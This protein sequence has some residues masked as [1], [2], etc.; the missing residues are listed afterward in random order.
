MENLL[1][2]IGLEIGLEKN[3]DRNLFFYTDVA[4]ESIGKLTES[5]VAINEEDEYLTKVYAI[6]DLE[7]KRPPIKIYI[8]SYGGDV[9]SCFGLLS[10]IMGSKTPVHTIV[11]GTAQ[12][13]GSLILICG[14]RRFAYPLSTVMFHQVIDDHLVEKTRD[15]EENL[16]ELKRIQAKLEEIVLE[17][18]KISR[19]RL[20]DVYNKKI[21]WY[22]SANEAI[23]FG[24]VDEIID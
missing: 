20:D 2:K 1:S 10:I 3:L 22:L 21:D 18:T 19:K 23:K 14:H 12:S 15:I 7:Y 6:Y 9:Y 11:T 8:D 17:R 24:V 4:Q 16:N 13:A 5:I